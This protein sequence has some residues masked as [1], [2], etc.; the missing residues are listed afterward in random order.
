MV[1]AWLSFEGATGRTLRACVP[2]EQVIDPYEFI[3]EDKH[4]KLAS[5]G[6]YEDYEWV[7][8]SELQE[9]IVDQD[10]AKYLEYIA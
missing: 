5:Q 6:Q 1:F 2:A 9:R 7:R 4:V 8:S 10:L 3:F